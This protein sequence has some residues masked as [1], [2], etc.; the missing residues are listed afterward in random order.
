MMIMKYSKQKW[1]TNSN[2][3]LTLIVMM[4]AM[5]M[6]NIMNIMNMTMMMVMMMVVVVILINDNIPQKTVD[7]I[8]YPSPNLS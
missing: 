2:K 4:T 3:I 7:V 1:N 6:M 5:L 8:T